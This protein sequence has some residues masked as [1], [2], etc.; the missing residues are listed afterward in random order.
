MVVSLDH[1][2]GPVLGGDGDGRAGFG[3]A[4]NHGV[5]VLVD[6][7]DVELRRDR[8]LA[9]RRLGSGRRRLRR[10][11]RGRSF[12]G[13]LC[14]CLGGY[15]RRLRGRLPA[16]LEQVGVGAPPQGV[17]DQCQADDG[18]GNNAG[19]ERYRFVTMAT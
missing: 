15:R 4:G 19:H 18:Y 16:F 11:G 1:G 2:K 3:L 6:A 5:A 10:F 12:R 13:G 8:Q 14:R 7:H 9:R 17:K